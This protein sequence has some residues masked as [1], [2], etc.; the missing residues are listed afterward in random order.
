MYS[1]MELEIKQ[2]N[3]Y[4]YL[5]QSVLQFGIQFTVEENKIIPQL[6]SRIQNQNQ[7]F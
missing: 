5:L 1:K 3:P 2:R 6:E 7:T 4:L